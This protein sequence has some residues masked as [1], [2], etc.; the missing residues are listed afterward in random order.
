MNLFL[1]NL[2]RMSKLA[3]LFKLCAWMKCVSASY[4]PNLCKFWRQLLE[5]SLSAEVSEST[6][7]YFYIHTPKKDSSLTASLFLV[8]FLI[9][10]LQNP[11]LNVVNSSID[12]GHKVCL[13]L[14][15]THTHTRDFFIAIDKRRLNLAALSKCCLSCG[16]NRRSTPR[17]QPRHVHGLN[18]AVMVCLSVCT[19]ALYEGVKEAFWPAVHPQTNRGSG[20]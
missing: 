2:E 10:R 17:L 8:L 4:I 15:H 16:W 14:S 6:F 19:K 11:P 9:I 7:P 13:H 20:L 1:S 5:K 12:V 3:S 18:T